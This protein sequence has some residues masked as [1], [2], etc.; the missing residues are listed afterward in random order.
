M[1]PV[2]QLALGERD[3]D[4][5]LGVVEVACEVD[6]GVVFVRRRRP[7]ASCVVGDAAAEEQR[8]VG[9]L[10]DEVG[11]AYVEHLQYK[12]ALGFCR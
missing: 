7:V 2:S 1:A 8:L 9:Y 10:E 12:S 5:D 6:V 4:G 3:V 11:P